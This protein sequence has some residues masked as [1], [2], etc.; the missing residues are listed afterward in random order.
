MTEPAGTVTVRLNQQQMELV[1]ALARREGLPSPAEALLMGLREYV[2]ERE[3]DVSGRVLLAEHRLEPGTGRALPVLRGQVLRITQLAGGQCADF[4]AF[5]LH[6]HKEHF[7]TGRT[8][9]MHGI[10]PRE[11]DHLWSAP[12]RDRVMYTIL[13]DTCG[14]NDVLYPRCSALLFDLHFG[15]SPHTNCH[16]IQ[17]EAQREYGLTPD[18]V[19]DSFNVWMNTGIDAA[20]QPYIAPNVA[21][22]GDHIDL[23]AHIDTL[24]VPN[25]C[26][27]DVMV[28]SNFALKPLLVQVYEGGDEDRAV[29]DAGV[30]SYP[31][32][33]RTP[34]DFR[35]PVVKADRALR[36]DPDYVPEYTNV[37]LEVHEVEVPVGP[38][39]AAALADLLAAGRLGDDAGEVLRFAFFSWYIAHHMRGP[40]HFRDPA[41]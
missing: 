1:L 7:H 34:A 35:Q 28:T 25:V 16:D 5:N 26:G 8:R 3:G 14:T 29:L 2:R 27:A 9:H 31:R 41:A 19:H 6:D 38:G 20:G 15:L 23:L 40:R 10:H 36:P 21:R 39:D 13:R 12:P 33:Q 32:S 11:G 17:A 22:E 30:P 4:N 24:A 37:P 18:D